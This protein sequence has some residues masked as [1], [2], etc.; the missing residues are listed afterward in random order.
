MEILE[1]QVLS[2]EL[3]IYEGR[4]EDVS[5]RRPEEIKTYDVLD[6]LGIPYERVDHQPVMTMEDCQRAD[7]ALG[8]PACK[9]LFLR[10]TQKTR[11]YL[12][13]MPGDKKFKTKD[14]SH[15]LGIARLSF[16]E[17]EFMAEYLGVYPGSAT[18][19]GLI[20]DTGHKVN[21]VMDKEVAEGEYIVCH[22]CANTSS[23]KLKTKDVLEKFLPWTG[24]E[25][26]FV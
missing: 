17:E 12:L 7:D 23:I 13:M 8:F 22:P 16:G 21:L 24:H 5:G 1:E 20:Q 25:P 26:A 6:Q 18:V 10:N 19:M 3:T 9:N 4:P 15:Q 2:K 11:F 14:L